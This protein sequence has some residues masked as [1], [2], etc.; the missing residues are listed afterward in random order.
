[1]K[2]I[3]LMLLAGLALVSCNCRKPNYASVDDY[4]VKKTSAQEVNYSSS[5]T[6]FTLWSPNADSVLVSI[7]ATQS[8]PEPVFVVR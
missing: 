5:E 4:P 2:K 7:Y 8:E 3:Y 1:M 6:T